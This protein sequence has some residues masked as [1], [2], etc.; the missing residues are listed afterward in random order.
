MK[1]NPVY[2]GWVGVF[3]SFLALTGGGVSQAAVF[4]TTVAASDNARIEATDSTGS[5]GWNPPAIAP[6]PNAFTVMA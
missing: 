6:T 2:S 5:L 3:F 4:P 1:T